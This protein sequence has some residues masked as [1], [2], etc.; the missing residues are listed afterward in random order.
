MLALAVADARFLALS[1]GL[2]GAV[3]AINAGFWAFVLRQEGRVVGLL[4][5]MGLFLFHVFNVG[6]AQLAGWARA[7]LHG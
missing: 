2:L 4:Q 1:A 6:N 5:V 3:L 7:W